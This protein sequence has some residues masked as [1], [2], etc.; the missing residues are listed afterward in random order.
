MVILMK[1]CIAALLLCLLLAGCSDAP[2]L[3]TT[4]VVLPT[5]AL[6]TEAM[7][8]TAEDPPAVPEFV[9]SNGPVPR[10][11]Q[12]ADGQW[13]IVGPA[14]SVQPAGYYCAASAWGD[15]DRDGHLELVYLAPGRT[16]GIRT[17]ELYVYDLEDGWPVCT[18]SSTLI[19]TGPVSY[20]QEQF[21]VAEDSKVFYRFDREERNEAY[22]YVRS[23]TELLPISLEN[24]EVLLA[25]GGELP[26]GIACQSNGQPVFGA[27]FA[28]L[29]A[30]GGVAMR[31]S[32]CCLIWREALGALENELP[33][34]NET[35]AVAA[36]SDNRVTVTAYLSWQRAEDGSVFCWFQGIEPV[37]ALQNPETLVGLSMDALQSLLGPC[38]FDLC[39]TGPA[40]APMPCWFTNDGKL[41]TAYGHDG[42]ELFVRDLLT[43]ESAYFTASNGAGSEDTVTILSGLRSSTVQNQERW[44][45][46]L[47]RTAKGTPDS[48]Q[49]RFVGDSTETMQLSY[50]GT[51]YT[52]S[53]QSGT[54]RYGHLIA[55]LE[56]VERD[57]APPTQAAYDSAI[58][59]LLSDD[60]EMTMERYFRHIAS[61]ILDPDFPRTRLLFSIY[62]NIEEIEPG[63]LKN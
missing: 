42:V 45:A 7:T 44:N 20:G 8:P 31:P 12:D 52:L 60:P 3:E 50:N 34:L 53:D 49:L 1:R 18:G 23:V 47:E 5:P 51:V 38:H 4:P 35:A 43:G 29:L 56:L 22:G 36:L 46:F 2:L 41:L 61:S 58:H 16:S 62:L 28:G 17:Q 24:G 63:F 6:P 26:D 48:V 9:F 54:Q 19:L 57:A 13:Q 33:A 37:P 39:E 55:D 40:S 59:Y 25:E 14:G 11:E 21:L 27:S 10:A 32:L 30:E 15:V